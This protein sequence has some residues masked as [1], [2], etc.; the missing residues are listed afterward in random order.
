MRL[1]LN[2]IDYNESILYCQDKC[3]DVASFKLSH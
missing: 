1:R 3:C 2:L